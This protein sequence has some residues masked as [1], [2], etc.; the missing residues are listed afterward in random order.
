MKKDN[1]KTI[2]IIILISIILLSG[3]FY[4]YNQVEE[5]AYQEG[6]SDAIIL[7]NQN[8]LNSLNQ[9]GYVSFSYVVG[10]ETQIINLIPSQTW[11]KYY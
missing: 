1:L 7:I 4:A 9:N 3:L 5:K 2:T 8:I 6:G 11:K 10:N